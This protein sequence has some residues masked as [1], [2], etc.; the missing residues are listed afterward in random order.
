MRRRSLA[1][2]FLALGIR[3]LLE[4]WFGELFMV[5]IKGA[6]S[7]RVV[8]FATPSVMC[9]WAGVNSELLEKSATA[10]K[11]LIRKPSQVGIHQ[12]L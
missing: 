12:L 11:K 8:R 2:A 3:R 4:D 6:V 7:G 10:G 9:A 1:R 5:I